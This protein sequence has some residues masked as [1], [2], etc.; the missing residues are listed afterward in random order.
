MSKPTPPLT[1][2]ERERYGRQMILPEI[3]EAGQQRLRAARVLLVGAGGLGSPAAL[4]L[5]AAGVGTLIICDADRVD[6][7]NLHRQVLHSE[8]SVGQ[9]KTRSAAAR[10][11]TLNPSLECIAHPVRITSANAL[12]LIAACDLVVD[13]SDNFPT[14]YLVN[15]A[16]VFLRKPLVY[17]AVDRFEGQVAVFDTTAAGPCYRCLF[18][19]PPPPGAVPSCAEAGVLGVVPGLI[20]LW[21]AAEALKILLGLGRPLRGRL[22]L[23]DLMDASTR[24]IEVRRDSACPVCGDAPTIRELID[25]EGFCLGRNASAPP[26]ESVAPAEAR[27]RIAAGALLV[28][29]READE[30]AAGHIKDAHLVPLS[31]LKQGT[32]DLSALAGRELVVTCRSGVRSLTACTLLEAQGLGPVVNVAGGLK[33]WEKG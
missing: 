9:P 11:L 16:C 27:R 28:D 15:D 19:E 1:P 4:Y 14:R 8:D 3:G 17:G 26:L 22:L 31:Q 32:A 29:V 10:L 7:S 30:F 20:G 23:I 24:E 13:G 21:Q 12:E 25:Y 6:R 5:A 33:A 2:D 18:P